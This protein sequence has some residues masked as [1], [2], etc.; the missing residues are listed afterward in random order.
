MCNRN[1]PSSSAPSILWHY[2]T[3]NT[4]N[5]N[6][7]GFY[8]SLKIISHEKQLIDFLLI[9]KFYIKVYFFKLNKNHNKK[10]LFHFNR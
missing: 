6:E 5:Y 7:Y 2:L 3:D 9:E 8:T 10:N 1:M 4:D